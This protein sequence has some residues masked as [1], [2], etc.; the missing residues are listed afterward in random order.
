MI[1][2]HLDLG[3]GPCPRNPYSR[4]EVHAVDLVAPEGMEPR[5]FRQAN[6]SLE[7][8]P[9]PDSTF[10][11]I[12][13][14]DF[15]EHIPRVLTA[16]DGRGT[17]FPFIELMNEIHRTLKPGGLLYALTPAYPHAATFQDPTHVNVITNI[18]SMYFCGDQPLARM[19]GYHGSFEALRNDWAMYPEDF[20]PG[21][22]LGWRRRLRRWRLKRSGRLS[23]LV[24]EFACVKPVP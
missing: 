3:C 8:I 1:T 23:H 16:A 10:D 19:Y 6:L 7:P 2:K 12:S 11:S 18:T 22:I 14:F 24:W 15:I 13:A 4:D 20:V 5:L 21:T 9:H 17:R